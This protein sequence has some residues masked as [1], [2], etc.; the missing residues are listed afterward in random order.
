MGF[1]KISCYSIGVSS[2]F[3]VIG[4]NLSL[5]TSFFVRRQVTLPSYIIQIFFVSPPI[6]YNAKACGPPWA[7]P[8]YR[9]ECR[10]RPPPGPRGPGSSGSGG[11]LSAAA[12]NMMHCK[13]AQL[14]V[15]VHI[16]TLW[17]CEFKLTLHSCAEI[18]GDFYWPLYKCSYCI[19][20]CCRRIVLRMGPV[21]L[22]R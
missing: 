18:V 22:S 5:W 19:T 21:L 6:Y 9:W 17:R 12:G 15:E 3:L 11:S 2:L 4:S 7:W 20:V 14:E 10:R 13:P 8:L 16:A 1:Y